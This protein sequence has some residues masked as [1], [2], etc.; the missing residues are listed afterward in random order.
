MSNPNQYAITIHA[1]LTNVP[2]QNHLE[3]A[4]IANYFLNT[5]HPNL[6]LISTD[7]RN[8]IGPKDPLPPLTVKTAA[9]G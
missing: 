3:A 9:I 6:T 5:I 8:M 2:A 1:I 4:A 7:A